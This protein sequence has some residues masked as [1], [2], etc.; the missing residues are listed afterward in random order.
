[1]TNNLGKFIKDSGIDEGN[2]NKVREK[3]K[4]ILNPNKDNFDFALNSVNGKKPNFDEKQKTELLAYEEACKYVRGKDAGIS[5][6]QLVVNV[7]PHK[8]NKDEF[9]YTV[10]SLN[11]ELKKAQKFGWYQRDAIK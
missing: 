7:E 3:L 11:A 9:Y 4:H 8:E 6:S 2:A 10:S 1:M 5:A